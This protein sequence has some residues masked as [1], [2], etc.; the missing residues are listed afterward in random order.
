MAIIF[1]LLW[2]NIFFVFFIRLEIGSI[3]FL[4]C[5]TRKNSWNA[6]GRIKWCL[7]YTFL[8]PGRLVDWPPALAD[9]ETDRVVW[10]TFSGALFFRSSL[11]T[12]WLWCSGGTQQIALV[13]RRSKVGPPER[14]DPEGD[15]IEPS[16]EPYPWTPEICVPSWRRLVFFQVI[17]PLKSCGGRP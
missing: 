9:S 7:V 17:V 15:D 13:T 12:V 10:R 11:W 8:D 16:T 6:N 1:Y 4:E 2:C 5:T 14:S 3:S